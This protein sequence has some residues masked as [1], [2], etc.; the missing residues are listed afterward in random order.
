MEKGAKAVIG[1]DALVSAAQTDAATER[2]LQ[3]LVAEGLPMGEAVQKTM[4][5]VGTDPS[6]GASLR[7]YPRDAGSLVVR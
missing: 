5:E 6:Y 4:A 3:H 1:W 7:V 2:L